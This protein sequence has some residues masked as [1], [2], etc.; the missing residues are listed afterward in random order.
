MHGN[1]RNVPGGGKP[2]I[3]RQREHD[4]NGRLGRSMNPNPEHHRDYEPMPMR[5]KD[6]EWCEK[7][8]R[9]RSRRTHQYVSPH[10]IP[11]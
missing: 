1:N 5:L 6:V 2:T 9:W 8:L 7:S 10:C 3:E 4:R 11:H